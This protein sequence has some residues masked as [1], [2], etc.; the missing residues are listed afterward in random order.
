MRMPVASEPKVPVKASVR[1]A[2][3]VFVTASGTG[4]GPTEAEVSSNEIL[5]S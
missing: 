5:P 2:E 1:M 3:I 4:I